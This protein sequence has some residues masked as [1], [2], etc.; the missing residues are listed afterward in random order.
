MSSLL[1]CGIMDVAVLLP[2]MRIAQLIEVL[3]SAN[4]ALCP[5]FDILTAESSVW[6]ALLFVFENHYF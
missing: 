2:R 6:K 4:L 3:G 5:G 1:V